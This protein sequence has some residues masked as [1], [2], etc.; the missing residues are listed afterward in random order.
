MMRNLLL[1]RK[2][3]RRGSVGPPMSTPSVVTLLACTSSLPIGKNGSIRNLSSNTQASL[4]I[5]R[6]AHIYRLVE[7]WQKPERT[8]GD[9]MLASQVLDGAEG[10]ASFLRAGISTQVANRFDQRIVMLP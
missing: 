5:E 1:W 3:L 4:R 2:K 10:R 9:S 7:G 8:L 6:Q